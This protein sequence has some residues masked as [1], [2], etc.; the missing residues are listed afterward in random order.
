MK[1]IILSLA[2]LL[3]P[4]SLWAATTIDA[5]LLFLQPQAT[6]S[7]LVEDLGTAISYRAIS[8]AEPLGITGFD[9]GVEV[10]ATDLPN[11]SLWAAALGGDTLD[12]IYLPKLHI[13]KGLPFGIDVGAFYLGGGNTEVE[14]KGAEIRYAIMEGGTFSPALAIRA[15]FSSLTGVDSLDLETQTIELTISKG[16]TI[17]TPYAGI[18]KVYITGTPTGIL[19]G[20]FTKEEIELN[21]T[22]VGLNINLGLL[23]IVVD[24]DKTGDA[25]SQSIKL[26]W[27]F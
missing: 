18:G 26:G 2:F 21:K 23:N 15:A 11:V 27:R 3:S 25:N 8:P 16:L 1:R 19:S 4:T 13:H 10:T 22:F 6:F 7:A 12:T 17:L 9:I 14:V 20:V 24:A 5:T